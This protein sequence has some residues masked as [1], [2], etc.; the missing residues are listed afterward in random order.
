MNLPIGNLPNGNLPSGDL[1][2]GNDIF[3]THPVSLSSNTV[4]LSPNTVS[5]S[6]S[7]TDTPDA[8]LRRVQHDT[9]V[10]A[11]RSKWLNPKS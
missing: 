3:A 11:Y 8:M 2:R 1:L 4:S 9:F 5:L 10:A 7:K 6:Q